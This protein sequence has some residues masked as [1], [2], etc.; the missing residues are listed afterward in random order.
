MCCLISCMIVNR[1]WG[2]RPRA[3]VSMV[4]VLRGSVTATLTCA[5]PGLGSSALEI[6]YFRRGRSPHFLSVIL[7]RILWG[8]NKPVTLC[9][10]R[11]Y[12]TLVSLFSLGKKATLS[13]FT[14][15]CFL[16][17]VRRMASSSISSCSILSLDPLMYSH[18]HWHILCWSMSIND[19]SEVIT[20]CMSIVAW[21]YE[22]YN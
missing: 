4:P 11:E 19:T 5:R 16:D 8:L 13:D 1:T 6:D 22:F 7:L 17:T 10:D 9:G 3:L 2:N 18:S 21:S 12:G 20:W 14:I 15:S